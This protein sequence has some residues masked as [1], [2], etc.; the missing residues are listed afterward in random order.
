MKQSLSNQDL[1]RQNSE[2][3]NTGGI[4]EEN[5]TD[6][7][8]PGFYD[9]EQNRAEVARFSDGSPAPF[10]I[11]DGVPVDWVIERD[12]SGKIVA[13]KSSIIAGFIRDGV[14]YTREQAS[15]SC[16]QQDSTQM[17]MQLVSCQQG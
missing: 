2:F 5:H 10:H 17:N 11:L 13:V 8:L 6:G 14:F 1:R 3:K 15:R 12:I 16:S 7:F 9:T 4:S